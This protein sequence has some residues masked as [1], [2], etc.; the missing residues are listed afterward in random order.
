MADPPTTKTT[1]A[2]PDPKSDKTPDDHKSETDSE[3]DRPPWKVLAA[4][5][6]TATIVLI[7]LAWSMASARVLFTELL[8][9]AGAIAVGALVGF[10]FG[11]PRAPNA[12]ADD[13][14]SGSDGPVRY[15]PSNNLEQVSDWLTKLLIGVGLVEVKQLGSV[16]NRI[17]VAVD[18]SLSGSVAGI[19]V[20]TQVVI[21]IFVLL[22]FVCSFL[23]TRI[24]YARL[25]T[26]AD[27]DILNSL[28]E[29]VGLYRR[30]LVEEKKDKDEVEKRAKALAAGELPNKPPKPPEKAAGVAPTDAIT[31]PA[32]IQQKLTEFENSPAD[33]D[34]DTAADIF[35][36]AEQEANGRQFEA[37][38]SFDLGSTLVINLRV[39]RLKGEP[40]DGQV[41]FCLHPTFNSPVVRV[42]AKGNLA[43]TEISSAGWFTVIA[44]LDR[45]ETILSYDLRKLP[46]VPEWF[47][48]SD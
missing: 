39:R 40:L 37:E 6:G 46:N 48:K 8:V 22:G 12:S 23:W 47:T 18:L 2:N 11:M 21:V 35:G 33:W 13:D 42:N 44:I 28:R 30:K 10:L 32:E 19:N 3:R 41:I 25:Q 16:L 43:E 4:Y 9:A 1:P 5:L 17:G 38:I 36:K 34:R 29:K 31:L 15:R 7:L 26:L 14:S 45:G 20:I 27:S 24:Y